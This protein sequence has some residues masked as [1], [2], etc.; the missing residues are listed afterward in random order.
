[1]PPIHLSCGVVAD[2]RGPPYPPDPDRWG[3]EQHGP[4]VCPV[5]DE[6]TYVLF[7][8]HGGAQY[9]AGWADSRDVD[10]T[11]SLSK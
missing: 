3:N 11:I 4:Y 2:Y 1:M 9:E 10:W 7:G 8:R 5:C 6:R